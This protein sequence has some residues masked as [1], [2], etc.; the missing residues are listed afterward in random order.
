MSTINTEL[1]RLKEARHAISNEL[2]GLTDARNGIH[3]ELDVLK[4]A[5]D[6]IY[7]EREEVCASQPGASVGSPLSVGGGGG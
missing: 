2:D 4:R 1:N 6:K 5:R 7:T 3:T